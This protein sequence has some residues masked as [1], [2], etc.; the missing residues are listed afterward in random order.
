M[1]V[2]HVCTVD[3]GGAY[4][5]A[6]RISCAMN[7]QGVDSSLLLRL[8]TKK[9]NLGEQAITNPI[10]LFISK[11]KNFFNILLS[12]K[13]I[14]N[15]FLGIDI[16]KNHLVIEADII[17]LHWVNYFISF[18]CLKQLKKT[19][20]P[21]VWVIHDMWLFTGG[22]HYDHY[23]G[24]YKFGCDMC[25]F[26]KNKLQQYL[27]KKHFKKKKMMVSKN[28]I[29]VIG[30]SE[31][32]IDCAKNS[33]IL[34]EVSMA[35]IHNPINIEVYHP[36]LNIEGLREKYE[37]SLL[38]KVILFGAENAT[39]SNIKGGQYLSEVAKRLPNEEY[40]IVV[41]GNEPNGKLAQVNLD[42]KY[43]GY[44]DDEN[45]LAEIYNLA[46]VF[47]APSE[48]EN[49]A[50]TVLEAMSCG[51]PVVAF[52]VG[53]MVDII[54]HKKNGYLADFKDI[55]SL[56]NGINWCISYAKSSYSIAEEIARENCYEEIGSKYVS[57]CKKLL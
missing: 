34:G 5:A 26:A 19:G 22:C 15:G 53:G 30:P 46:D 28:H 6:V 49:Y 31:W 44:I 1:K 39:N 57:I 23:C 45:K 25:P 32:I 38:K 10:A 42:V 20:K 48:Q 33:E 47:V 56:V 37:I 4:K 17:F 51:L 3:R 14:K 43:L 29:T 13:N 8:K 52:P 36:Q 7:T 2:L 41:F 54:H 21:I 24:R 11:V 35:C 18:K 55:S 40:Q 16:S 9:E 50:N 27:I 12:S